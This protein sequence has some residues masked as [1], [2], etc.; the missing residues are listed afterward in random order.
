MHRKNYEKMNVSCRLCERKNGCISE[1]TN[2]YVEYSINKLNVEE[3]DEYIQRLVYSVESWIETQ[4][5][6]GH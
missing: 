5:T 3:N 6:D 2:Y 4:I 1:L